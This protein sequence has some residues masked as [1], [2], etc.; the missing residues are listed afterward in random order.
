[1]RRRTLLTTGSAATLSAG[2]LP[3]LKFLPAHAAPTGTVV[4]AFGETINSLDLHRSGTNRPSYQVAVN[5]YDRLIRFGTNVAPDGTLVYDYHK[6]E[7][8][9]AESWEVAPD[10]L[11]ITFKLKTATFQDG[12]PVTAEDVKWSFDRAVSVGGFPTTQMKAGGLIKPDQFEAVDTKTFRVKL[13]HPSKLS[14]PD[15]AVPVPFVL[16]S[17]LVLKHAT[18]KD[19]WGTEFVH[20]NTVGSGAFSVARWDPGQ[21]LIYVRNDHWAGGPLPGAKRVVIREV[22]SDATRRALVERGD[23]HLAFDI[24]AKDAEEMSKNPKVKVASDKIDNSLYVLC[25]NLIFEP[26]KDRRVRQAVAWAL[27][28]KQ[29]FSQA[30]YSRGVKMWGGT[31]TTPST[32]AWPQPFPYAH[33][34]DKAKALLAQTKYK[35]GFSVPLSFDIGTSDWAEPAALL[36]QEA[37]TRIGI[38]VTLDRI[39]GANWRT[40]ALVDKKLPLLIENFGGWLNT[41]DYYF[42]WAYLKGSLFNASNY[43]NPEVAELVGKTLNMAEDDPQYAPLIKR[44]IAIGFADVPR[45]PLWQPTLNSAMSPKLRGYSF[46]FH[47]QIDARTYGLA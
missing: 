42:Y 31:E 11:T 22:P 21:Q 15:L 16:N 39:P 29:I 37:L 10:G 17:K 33:D 28:Y 2:A 6:L 35:D 46:W 43:D 7:G 20:R 1:M 18:K 24:P 9:L 45:I 44:L 25:P 12:T 13:L 32:I 19:P 14:L 5:C 40:V 34:P 30:A 4:V 36:I 8:E 47:R 38:K 41:P 3:F 27:P 23:V 26:F